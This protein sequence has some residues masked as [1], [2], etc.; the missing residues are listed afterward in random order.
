MLIGKDSG[1]DKDGYLLAIGRRLEGC[2]YSD[3]CLPEAHISTEEAVHRE[4]T[5]HVGLHGCDRRSLVGG[6][7]E[8]K[9]CL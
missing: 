2:S 3:F 8:G 5:L 7:F 4:G 1:G 6:V 9:R